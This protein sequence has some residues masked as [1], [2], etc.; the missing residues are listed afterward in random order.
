MSTPGQHD[1]PGKS[2]VFISYS[3]R[4]H[5]PDWKAHEWLRATQAPNASNPLS[6]LS[7]S[8]RDGVLRQLATDIARELSGTVLA[9]MSKPAQPLQPDRTYVDRFPLSRGVGQREETL[10]GRE[11]ELAL[12]DLAFTQPETAI[13][14]L[15]AWGGVGKSMLV[16]HW[17]RRLQRQGWCGAR[18]VYAWSFYSQG[19]SEDRQASDDGFFAH[20]LAWF[21]VQCEPTLSPWDKGRLLADAVARERVLL[22]LDGVEPLQYPPGPMGGQLRSPGVQTSPRVAT[23]TTTR[24]RSPCWAA[25]SP[26]RT[27]ATSAAATL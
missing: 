23:W 6:E 19:T 17:L 12:L 15:V 26:A 20:A 13:V 5:G 14:S 16:Q 18:R 25:S 7:D 27:A 8:A 1:R 10:I 24:S 9:G 22:V 11:Q 2:R 3:H 4:G 21:G